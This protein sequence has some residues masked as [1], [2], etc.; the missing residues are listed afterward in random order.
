MATPQ[1]PAKISPELWK[2]LDIINTRTAMKKKHQLSLYTKKFVDSD[3]GESI[4][5]GMGCSGEDL[6]S[7]RGL[8]KESLILPA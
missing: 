4:L 3:E 7:I 5:L 1:A 2:V 8:L 6:E